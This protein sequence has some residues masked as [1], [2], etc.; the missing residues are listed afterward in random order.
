MDTKR[1]A[2]QQ[3]LAAALVML[4]TVQNLPA[5]QENLAHRIARMTS[6]EQVAA[7]NALLDR[8]VPDPGS[9]GDLTI[10]IIGGNNA[11]LLP[12]LESKIE[13]IVKSRNPA[14]LFN[15]KGVDPR[16]VEL[17]L[18]GAIAYAGNGQALR[19][20]SKLLRLD[21][22]R[23]DTMVERVM[24]SALSEGR[25][26]SVVYQGFDLKDP[27]IDSRLV[28]WIEPLLVEELAK[29]GDPGYENVHGRRRQWAEA[30]ADRYGG[31]PT[32]EQWT[33]DPLVSRLK[34]ELVGKLYNDVHRFTVEAAAKRRK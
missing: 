24:I 34:P 9:V 21:E 20:A 22:K 25:A 19:E 33:S 2:R 4:V 1:L 32:A 5:Q 29:V 12:M 11:V 10:L 26:F 8:G 18:C 7:V 28:P 23:F 3:F 13:Q 17:I 27:A 14:D 6:A 15:D 30:L 16:K 31:A